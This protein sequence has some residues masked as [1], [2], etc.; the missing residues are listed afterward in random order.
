MTYFNI[1]LFGICFLIS[2]RAV[3]QQKPATASQTNQNKITLVIHGGAGTITRQN[4][5]PEKE[6]AYNEALNQA[7]QAGYAILKKGGTSLDAVVA[8]IRVMEDSPLFNAGKG[9]VFTHEGK[10]ELDAAIMDGKTLKAGAVAGVTIIRNP[11]TAARAVMEKSEHVLMIGKGAEQFAK[12]N[13]LG[14]VSPTY[15]YTEPRYQQ[16]EKIRQKE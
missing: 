15:F 1:Y 5:T 7:L 6:K 14:I 4:M 11:I 12:D 10:N 9:A 16:L 13:N 3:A 2:L 8:T